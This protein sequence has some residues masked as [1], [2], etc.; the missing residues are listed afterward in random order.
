MSLPL[1]WREQ[2]SA[3]HL[4]LGGCGGCALLVDSLLRD[5][6]GKRA[7][8]VECGSPRQ[9]RAIL[10]TGCACGGTDEEA[11]AVVAGAPGE[12]RL[13]AVGDCALGH[14]PFA[15]PRRGAGLPGWLKPDARL[16]GCPVTP[17]RLME[18]LRRDTP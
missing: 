6:A 7:P 11:S 12:A 4:R 16:P 15:E 9:A 8:A 3:F 10:V 13:I 17:E 14:G 18:E 2:H 1:P 5:G